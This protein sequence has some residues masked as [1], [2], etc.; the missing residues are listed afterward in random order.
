MA[1]ATQLAGRRGRLSACYGNESKALFFLSHS[2]HLM[3]WSQA[4]PSA[5]K[6]GRTGQPAT[7]LLS[8]YLGVPEIRPSIVFCYLQLLVT[9]L[10]I[11]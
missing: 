5:D 11:F 10:S 2:K 4:K 7:G 9:K 1:M 8:W 6:D 3:T